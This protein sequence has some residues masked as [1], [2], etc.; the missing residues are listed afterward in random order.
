MPPTIIFHWIA[1]WE[2]PRNRSSH[3]F[4]RD[5]PVESRFPN[6]QIVFEVGNSL[7]HFYNLRLLFL[8]VN[9]LPNGGCRRKDHSLPELRTP[10]SCQPKYKEKP[11]NTADRH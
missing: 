6:P 4:D 2:E 7:P 9:R 3:T 11:Q 10:R 1:L 5:P 8:S